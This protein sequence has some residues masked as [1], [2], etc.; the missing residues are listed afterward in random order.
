MHSN[1]EDKTEITAAS[2]TKGAFLYMERYTAGSPYGGGWFTAIDS[3]DN[4]SILTA[5]TQNG[6]WYSSPTNDAVWARVEWIEN[7]YVRPEWW[8]A[9]ADGTDS[10]VTRQALQSALNTLY[11]VKLASGT[12]LIDSTIVMDSHLLSGN[13]MMPS[14]Q[15]TIIKLADSSNCDML[16]NDA[17]H[18][19]MRIEGIYFDG[20]KDNQTRGDGIYFNGPITVIEKCYL[21]QIKATGIYYGKSAHSSTLMNTRIHYCDSSGVVLDSPN[22]IR[23]FGNTIQFNAGGINLIEN[24]NVVG[25]YGNYFE[26]NTL[27]DIKVTYGTQVDISNNYL[28]ALSDSAIVVHNASSRVVV[29]RNQGNA[30]K[31]HFVSGTINNWVLWDYPTDAGNNHQRAMAHEQNTRVAATG[32][33]DSISAVVATNEQYQRL[34]R[35]FIA[36]DSLIN[37]ANTD[38]FKL[39]LFWDGVSLWDTTFVSGVQMQAKRSWEVVVPSSPGQYAAKLRSAWL[40]ITKNGSGMRTPGF[41]VLTKFHD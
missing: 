22:G 36:S 5:N 26:N 21:T 34:W 7:K 41:Y 15:T 11:H 32:L 27:Y 20:N 38:N 10:L 35:C 16:H 12:Y 24:A 13:N 6:A 40:T 23:V 14:Y 4:T 25:I 17:S 3:T 37:G 2:G 28:N 19:M 33:L 8:G 31:I 1:V 18:Q 30:S 9:Q 29:G 39:E